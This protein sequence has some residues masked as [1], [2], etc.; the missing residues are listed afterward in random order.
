LVNITPVSDLTEN[1]LTAALTA[2]TT[3]PLPAFL[4]C[5]LADEFF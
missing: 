4:A 5:Y 1:T 2:P 3:A